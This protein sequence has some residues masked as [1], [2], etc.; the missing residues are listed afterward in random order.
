V[1]DEYRRL[2]GIADILDPSVVT[3]EI[4]QLLS[5]SDAAVA[6]NEKNLPKKDD[7]V[8]AMTGNELAT[9]HVRGVTPYYSD[10][11]FM[12]KD[13]AY[14][15]Q[16]LA[17]ATAYFPSVFL[18]L[19]TYK[20]DVRHVYAGYKLYRV[21]EGPRFTWM[22]RFPD[23]WIGKRGRL[24]LYP[25][26]TENALVHVSTSRYTPENSVS[27]YQDDVFLEKVPLTE[28]HEHTFKL[29]A[30]G[31][32][33]PTVFRFEIERTFVPK[34]LRLNMDKRELGAFVRLEP[35]APTSQ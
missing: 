4:K 32:D 6:S 8:L 34:E 17:E 11:S 18:N 25:R 29:Q 21:I 16:E 13:G 31:K 12:N 35:F 27:V 3:P 23:G 19:W 26:Y 20:L 9:W 15:M 2:Y 10:G 28:G 14:R 30:T 33:A 1:F 24:I 22:G 5:L 7:Y